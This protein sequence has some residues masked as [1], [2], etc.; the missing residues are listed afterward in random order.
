MTPEERR[1]LESGAI[2]PEW[3]RIYYDACERELLISREQ[4]EL[5]EPVVAEFLCGAP[6]G[7]EARRPQPDLGGQDGQTDAK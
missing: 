3:L 4:R 6:V 1:I 7:R 2:T 5:Y